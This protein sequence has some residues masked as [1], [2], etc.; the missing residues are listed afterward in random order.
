MK[1]STATTSLLMASVDAFTPSPILTQ[2]TAQTS[3]SLLPDPVALTSAIQTSS[4][5]TSLDP[6][7]ALGQLA[8]LSSVGFGVAYSNANN[9]DWSYEYKV[10][11]DY[12]DLAVL[13]ESADSV[14]EKATT[15]LSVPK[16]VTEPQK[17]FFDIEDTAPVPEPEPVVE[18]P[19]VVPAAA[20]AV[21]A[22]KELLE[23]TEKAKAAVAKKGVQ[24]TKDKIS[25]KASPAAPAEE[26]EAAAVA[27][28]ST[29]TE[30]ANTKK[31]GGKRRF[32][33]GVSLIAAATAV[34]LGR[35][36]IK[37]YLGKGML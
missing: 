14:R 5:L 31:P 15:S 36:V 28:A 4:V 22:S 32:V 27:V 35:N 11:N 26:K 30:V 17:V 12:S 7:E 8:L 18:D 9:K 16:E 23:S 10:D 34:T 6:A 1:I 13:G 19:K 33:K 24:D 37:A 21:T 3:L 2:R 20:K 29:S 25:S